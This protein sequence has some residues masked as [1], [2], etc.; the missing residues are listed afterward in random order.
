MAELVSLLREGTVAGKEASAWA[1][2][3]LAVDSHNKFL[4]THEGA[5]H[6]LVGILKDRR[7]P[8]MALPLASFRGMPTAKRLSKK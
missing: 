8:A 3:N 5:V 2:R 4:L 7:S 1:L 6:A